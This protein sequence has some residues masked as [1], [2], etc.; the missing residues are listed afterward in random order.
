M[1]MVMASVFYDGVVVGDDDEGSGGGCIEMMTVIRMVSAVGSSRGSNGVGPRW[2]R[3]AVKVTMVLVGR[4][5]ESSAD[6]WC[7]VPEI[8][9]GKLF[10]PSEIAL[11]APDNLERERGDFR[12][13]N[14]NLIAT[15]QIALDN[16]LVTLEKRLKIEKCNARIEFSKPQREDT[17]QFTLDALKLSPC[18][19]TF[20]ITAKICPRLP[21][22]EFVEPPSEDEMVS[23]IKDLVCIFGKSSGLDRL[24]PSRAQILDISLA[25]KENIPYPRFT[26]VINNHFI[27][28]DNTISMRNMINLH[29]IR[30]DTLLGTLK[31]VSKKEEY[32][33]YG[34]L[35]LEEMINQD[36]KDSKSY[37]TYLAFATG[38]AT[39]KKARKFKKIASPS[40]KLSPVLEEEPAKK[41]K[42]AKKPIPAKQAKTAKKYSIVQT[43]GVVIKD[44]PVMI[45]HNEDDDIDMMP[46]VN[47][48]ASRYEEDNYVL[49]ITMNSHNDKINEELYKDVNID[50]T[51][52]ADHEIVSMMNVMVSHEEPS[53]QTPSLLTVHVTVIL[54]NSTTAATTVP[55]TILPFTPIPQLSTPTPTPTKETTSPPVLLKFSSLFGFDRRVSALEKDLSQFKQSYTVEFEK[56]AQAEKDRYITK[57][58]IKD[59]I[60]D[61][62]KRQLPHIL[63]KE[64]VVL[65]KSS[66][67]LKSIY[68]VAASLTE[69]ELKKILLDKMQ[70]S[71]SYRAYSL[72]RDHKD[73]DKDEDPLVGSYQGL[74]K[75]KTS[76]DAEP[77][78]GS[79]FKES[80]SS[81]SKGTKSQSKSFGKSA[82]AEEP[83]FEA[84][85][86]EMPHNQGSDL[87]N[88]NDQPN[89]EDAL[90]CDWFKKPERPLNPNPN[91][92]AS[93]PVN[94]RPTLTWISRIAH[95]E[96][97]SLTFDELMSTPIDFSA[98][99][100]NNLKIKNLI[101]EHLVGQAFN[102][103]KD[104]CRRQVELEC[105]FK[106]CYKAVTDRLDWNNPEENEYPFDLSKPLS[107]VEDR[108]HQVVHVDYFINNDLEYLKGGSSSRKYTTS[109]TK[110]KAAKYD[111][112]QGIEGMV[113]TLWSPVK[114][115]YDRYVVWGITHWVTHVKVMKWYDYGHLEEI[116]VQR[117]DKKLY[118][119]KEGDFPRSNLRDIKDMLLFL[120]CDE[121]FTSVR[122]VLLNSASNLRMDYQP[123]RRWSKLDSKRSHIMIKAIDQQ[124]FERRLMRNLEKF[125]GGRDYEEDL[126]LLE[127]T[128]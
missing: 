128:R 67:Q 73:K 78:K 90:R 20:L 54:E 106:E 39:P 6:G 77:S 30:D 51:P 35:I 86:T 66:P 41:P 44:T 3:V 62:I 40:K 117:E 47:K 100:M 97:P 103:L 28:K 115:A 11:A 34:A 42:Q 52:S 124:L 7:G 116:E 112:I 84:A 45:A 17:Y 19:P 75:R 113:L 9:A 13:K 68:E 93:K 87:G 2:R 99:V 50:N 102:L 72:K 57:K 126:R 22:Q 58:S 38:K 46:I 108:G 127:R 79:K 10:R 61:E 4:G 29:T 111:D 49:L 21:D 70:K 109:T 74:K 76:K 18:Y 16:A 121:T 24:R 82:Q 122:A 119:F 118:K 8:L 98:Y 114:V 56:E 69:F 25:R 65:A 96:K 5:D 91:W 120:F 14:M 55:P 92:N 64:N 85:D 105:H 48:D 104:T 125:V 88:T 53:T 1:R 59:I 80:K 71:K 27:S 15:Q 123:K 26:K 110:T 36:I 37:K 33:K 94:F 89:V 23:F 32:Q 60:K 63:P 31:F 83:V 81:T 107:L 43:T 101:Q 12:V 95:A